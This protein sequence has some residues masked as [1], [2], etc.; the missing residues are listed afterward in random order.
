MAQEKIDKWLKLAGKLLIITYIIMMLGLL[1][2][3]NSHKERFTYEEKPI[4]AIDI[5]F[6]IIDGQ[7][8]IVNHTIEGENNKQYYTS[9][10]IKQKRMQYYLF[11]MFN[12]TCLMGYLWFDPDKRKQI[13]KFEE[14]L[15][16]IIK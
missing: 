5:G 11:Y 3:A 2:Y 12:A 13:N 9:S 4:D 10:E 15:M 14:K 6:K 8:I 1:L 16:R 7:V